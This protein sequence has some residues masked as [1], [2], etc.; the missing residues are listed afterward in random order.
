MCTEMPARY[1]NRPGPFAQE[2]FNLFAKHDGLD[3][4]DEGPCFLFV[5]E[6]MERHI[7]VS[8]VWRAASPPFYSPLISYMSAIS[9]AD[10]ARL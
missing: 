1:G 2:P 9:I 6:K 3:W 7:P 8:T 5:V 4:I 10:K